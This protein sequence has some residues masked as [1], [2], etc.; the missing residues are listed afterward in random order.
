MKFFKLLGLFTLFLLA[1]C[2]E[3]KSLRPVLAAADSLLIVGK[4]DSA[5]ALLDSFPQQEREA[6]PKKHRMR[7][8]L[9]KA[10]AQN[11]AYIP[12]TSDSMVKAVADY[13]DRHGNPNE[14]MTANYV[15]GCAYYDMGE[16]PLALRYFHEACDRADTTAA[17]CDWKTLAKVHG[18]MAELFYYQNMF[19][20]QLASLKLS[21]Q[22]AFHAKDTLLAVI[23]YAKESNAY[24][25]IGKGDSALLITQDACRRLKKMGY[26]HLSAQN[27]FPILDV[28]LD[29]HLYDEAGR[30]ISDYEQKSG[31]FDSLH[32]V[33]KGKES[34]Y[35]MKGRY[36]VETNRL[37]SAKTLLYKALSCISDPE[38]L[39][40]ASKQL[41]N[42]YQ[43][44]GQPDSVVKYSSL[45]ST[46]ND[47]VQLQTSTA[48]LQQMQSLYD[49]TRQQQLSEKTML[50]LEQSKRNFLI[51]LFTMLAA[52]LLFSFYIVYHRKVEIL[53]RKKYESDLRLLSRAKHEQEL[54]RSADVEA[55]RVLIAEKNEQIEVLQEQIVEYETRKKRLAVSNMDDKIISSEIFKLFYSY[56]EAIIPVAPSFSEW[57]QLRTLM[58]EKCPG[59]YA[60]LVE[61]H[62]LTLADYDMCILMRLRFKP[63]QISRLT[64]WKP[65]TITSKRHRIF[66]KIFGKEDEE[67]DFL[68]YLNSIV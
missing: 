61:K 6:L 66:K 17:D 27:A 12:F 18:L 33:K 14:Q 38:G 64:G 37:D 7:Y 24:S 40:A 34:Y 53:T 65:S 1:A 60:E 30:V 21:Q 43:K 5:Y 49:Y 57:M 55:N 31:F 62:K 50:A 23:A 35:I 3:P 19:E 2:S 10:C 56:S 54:L 44:S 67:N 8:E 11:S 59:F 68:D 58:N 63:S 42:L 28:L 25:L 13:Y 47:S 29:R 26:E 41:Q 48:T 46:Y 4:A 39:Y 22:A 15:L 36:C 32:Q 51:L 9:L 45:A 16:A 52:A 20:D